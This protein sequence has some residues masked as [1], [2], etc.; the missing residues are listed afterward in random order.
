M[1][2]KHILGI[3]QQ[4]S[5]KVAIIHGG[6]VQCDHARPLMQDCP[7]CSCQHNNIDEYFGK[8]DDCG[9]VFDA[10]VSWT[11]TSRDCGEVGRCA[12]SCPQVTDSAIQEA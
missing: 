2:S 12:P 3:G 8:C 4:E 5:G 10:E 7:Q 11:S 6:A 9:L 1:S